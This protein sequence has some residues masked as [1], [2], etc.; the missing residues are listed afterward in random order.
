MGAWIKTTNGELTLQMGFGSPTRII[1]DRST[2]APVVV[3]GTQ[4]HHP[5]K[6]EGPAGRG[7]G[8]SKWTFNTGPISELFVWRDCSGTYWVTPNWR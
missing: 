6:W 8:V 1:V 3:E 5:T 4:Q 2:D 7:P